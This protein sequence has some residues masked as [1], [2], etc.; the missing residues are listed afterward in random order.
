[1]TLA[2]GTCG[3]AGRTP[4]L[5]TKSPVFL[6]KALHPIHTP[7]SLVQRKPI[8][9][10]ET[11]STPLVIAFAHGAST[12]ARLWV[13]NFR[14]GLRETCCIPNNTHGFPMIFGSWNGYES[15]HWIPQKS[16]GMF[17]CSKWQVHLRNVEPLQ[18][19][20]HDLP[21]MHHLWFMISVLDP[22]STHSCQ[23]IPYILWVTCG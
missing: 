2:G 18:Y 3:L 16:N 14:L 5:Q 19:I 11:T 9:T 8:Q 6:I 12:L 20:S 15:S 4:F 22:Y 7:L 23:Y 13:T 21:L 10:H 1:M 17:Y